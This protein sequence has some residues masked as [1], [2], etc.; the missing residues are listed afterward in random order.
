VVVDALELAVSRR[1]TGRG[2]VAH[3]D[4]GSR[5]ASEHY[6]KF[7]ATQGTPWSMSRGGDRRHNAPIGSFFASLQEGLVHDAYL[8]TREQAR[9]R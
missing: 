3:A 7:P 4:R 5:Y 2:R 9:Q 1:L 6:Q 8:A